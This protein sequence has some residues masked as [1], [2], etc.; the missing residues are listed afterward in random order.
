MMREMKDHELEL[1]T[2]G[3]DGLSG[4]DDVEVVVPVMPLTPVASTLKTEKYLNGVAKAAPFLLGQPQLLPLSGL[5]TGYSPKNTFAQ[6]PRN[7]PGAPKRQTRKGGPFTFKSP[8]L[9]R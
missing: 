9:N 3:R 6:P 2:G 8:Y 4:G 1:V 7:L 5:G